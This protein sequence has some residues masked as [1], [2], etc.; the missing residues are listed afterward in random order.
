MIC[1]V[2]FVQNIWNCSKYLNLFK[3]F[4]E[5]AKRPKT[6]QMDEKFTDFHFTPNAICSHSLE[7]RELLFEISLNYRQVTIIF[8]T[9]MT[10]LGRHFKIY[11]LFNVMQCV[12]AIYFFFVR[13]GHDHFKMF[14]YFGYLWPKISFFFLNQNR[15]WLKQ[16]MKKILCVEFY[17]WGITI[18]PQE[19]ITDWKL[20]K[21]IWSTNSNIGSF[22][23]H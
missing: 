21:A 9:K 6:F 11:V 18:D 20:L 16:A 13:H 19:A 4:I 7:Y 22:K 15:I 5:R 8:H 12:N 10:F 1:L 23:W 3:I 14:K 2:V 17:W